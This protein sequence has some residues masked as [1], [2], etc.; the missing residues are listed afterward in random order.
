M[1]QFNQNNKNG[2]GHGPPA[3]VQAP[4]PTVIEKRCHV[5]TSQYRK[6]MEELIVKG[7]SYSEIA[8]YFEAMGESVTRKNLSNH[9]ERHMWVEK[10]AYRKIIE[11][12]AREAM[13]DVD[14]AQGFIMTKRALLEMMVHKGWERFLTGEAEIGAKELIAI[15]DKME[16]MEAEEKSVAVDEMMSEFQA[17]ADAVKLSVPEAM[18]KEIHAQFD[19]NMDA[20]KHKTIEQLV[21][22]EPPQLEEGE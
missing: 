15:I 2:R 11:Q 20:R 22:L 7:L 6:D 3:R 21:T 18:W 10:A 13:I 19:L 12:R 17:F 9:H 4:V 16:R 5:C 14:E 8:R 1:A